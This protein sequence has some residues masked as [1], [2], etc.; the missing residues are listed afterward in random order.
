MLNPPP[1]LN[2]DELRERYSA[3]Y[4]H[5]TGEDKDEPAG[6]LVSGVVDLILQAY[7]YKKD[8]DS[9]SESDTNFIHTL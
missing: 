7:Y 9:D 8:K 6:R 3:M 4:A 1:R 2:D 5:Y